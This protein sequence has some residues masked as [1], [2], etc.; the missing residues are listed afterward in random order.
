MTHRRASCGLT[1]SG[2][3]HPYT[4]VTVWFT[5]G[6]VK[7]LLKRPSLFSLL[8]LQTPESLRIT[9]GRAGHRDAEWPIQ[10]HTAVRMHQ[11]AHGGR[12]HVQNRGGQAL[13]GVL[14]TVFSLPSELS[15]THLGSAHLCLCRTW[16]SRGT[17][18]KRPVLL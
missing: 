4:V 2:M 8:S 13:P 16:G 18:L 5:T 14:S 6:G 9:S 3:R 12:R 1:S 17:D 15:L 10:A 11:G 7:K